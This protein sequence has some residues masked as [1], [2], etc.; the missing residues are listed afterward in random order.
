MRANVTVLHSSMLR[1]VV[2]P[3][4]VLAIT[5]CTHYV[6]AVW[7]MQI[8]PWLAARRRWVWALVA[9]LVLI[10]MAARIVHGKWHGEKSQRVGSLGTVEASIVALSMIPLGLVRLGVHVGF[11]AAGWFRRRDEEAHEAASPGR[12]EPAADAA[13]S[14]A[15]AMVARTDTP[16]HEVPAQLTRRQIIE[17]VGGAAALAASGTALGWGMVRGRHAF[18]IEEVP[19]RIPGLPRALDGYT[20]VQISD[21]HVGLFVGD[22]ELGEGLER[23][24]EARPDLVVATGDLVDHDERYIPAMARALGS[25]RA[26]D[27]VAA[28]LGNHDYYTGAQDVLAGLRAAGVRAL[29]NEGLVLRG[30]DGGGFALL[31]VADIFAPGAREEPPSLARAMAMVPPDRPRILLAHQ[32][33]FFVE[34]QGQVALQLSGHT[35]GGQIN[36]GFRP[37]SLFMRYLAGRYVEAGSTLWVNRGF[38]VAGPPTR[39]GAPPE[40]TKIVLVSA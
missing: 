23:V 38:G 19:V 31:G 26:R 27:G 37:A 16:A 17:G 9:S 10:P 5:V 35:H 20:I 30:R 22:R 2:L 12:E 34:S 1:A 7:A 6:L 21:I 25:I 18:V 14:A 13:P 15:P 39:I 36:P 4:M 32:P 29:V 33:E 28:I 11:G 8:S 40:V 24:A 3:L